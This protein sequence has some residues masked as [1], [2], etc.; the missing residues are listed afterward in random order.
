MASADQQLKKCISRLGKELNKLNEDTEHKMENI[1]LRPDTSEMLVWYFV[2]LG[3]DT[4]YKDGVYLGQI[5]FPNT[6]PFSPPVLRFITPNG[7][8]QP[9]TTL[10]TSFSHYHKESWSPNWTAEKMVVGLISMMFESGVRGNDAGVGGIDSTDDKK[11]EMAI[12]SMIFNSKNKI[13]V[14]IFPDLLIKYMS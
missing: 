10:C 14:E 13:F 2:I 8:F 5:N 11:R 7:R 12:E 3:L 4:P 9:N 1:I 6:Y